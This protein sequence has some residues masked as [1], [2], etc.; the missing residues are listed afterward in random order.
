MVAIHLR[1][2]ILQRALRA[3]SRV[4]FSPRV[5]RQGPTEFK[6]GP[7]KRIHEANAA[8]NPARDLL[9]D[10]PNAV[11]AKVPMAQVSGHV[12]PNFHG[13]RRLALAQKTHHFRIGGNATQVFEVAFAK[14]AQT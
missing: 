13:R 11:P 1:E 9:F 4:A 14:P 6:S 7:A 8:D 5:A 10:G 3:F 12:P 2:G